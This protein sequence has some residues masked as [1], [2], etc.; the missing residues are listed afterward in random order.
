MPAAAVI[1]QEF[2]LDVLAT[3]VT[4]SEHEVLD[5]VE[6]AVMAGLV[7]ET[8]TVDRFRFA[9]TLI[10]RQVLGTIPTSVRVRMHHDV[11]VA[12]AQLRAASIDGYLGELA[13]HFAEAAKVA[14][15]DL[16]VDY[17]RR[18]G[19]RAM[20]LVA[21]EEA[22]SF[23]TRAVDGLAVSAPEDVTGRCDL[24]L[25]LGDALNRSG[26]LAAGASAL[27]NAADLA[28]AAND[29]ERMAHA[30]LQY[31]GAMTVGG[32]VD[33]R[34][35][36]L[37]EQTLELVGDQAPALRV[38]VMA[39]LA[40]ALEYSPG[41]RAYRLSGAA[42][43]LARAT[44]DSGALAAALFARVNLQVFDTDARQ[45]FAEATE[46]GVLAES[47]GDDDLKLMADAWCL[48]GLLELG[49]GER[50]AAA[51]PDMDAV[52]TR[53]RQPLYQ[54]G[55]AGFQA[56][57]KL[58]LG[59][60]VEAEQL[61]QRA[62]E[63]GQRVSTQHAIQNQLV[64]LITLRWCQGRLG[65]V[66][67]FVDGVG[68]STETF[69]A[70]QAIQAWV[71]WVTGNDDRAHELLSKIAASDFAGV[72]SG[73]YSRPAA[74]LLSEVVA[75]YGDRASAAVLYDSLSSSADVAI[76]VGRAS[77]CL[78]AGARFL[79]V[80]ARTLGRLDDAERHL[81]R[82]T[83]LNRDLGARPFVAMAQFEHARV[84]R[85]RGAA[86]DLARRDTSR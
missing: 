17:A 50:A 28:F 43:E 51:M 39:R 60:F 10:R 59:D 36:A 65:E 2:D 26:D 83:A 84:L 19:D 77:V 67:V 12:L 64:Q 85:E 71:A 30:A 40:E 5:Q 61:M 20:T 86:N 4:R 56:M 79:G 54:W 11:G 6:A 52:A 80:L 57:H 7:L 44:G 46:L 76:V 73:P 82:A 41:D 69:P 81:E 49:E 13:H 74:A 34:Q 16:A 47:L 24:L 15:A 38:R 31:G 53:L 66:A 27:T 68:L 75:A 8:P 23:Y 48:V 29:I 63:M 70:W 22:A 25:R 35:V 45:R 37:L 21:W 14:D 62:M 9:H 42:V 78:G 32:A 58:L 33:P 18:A 72:V 3:I 1:G 55:A